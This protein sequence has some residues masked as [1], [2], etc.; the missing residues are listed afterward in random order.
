VSHYDRERRDRETER[1]KLYRRRGDPRGAPDELPWGDDKPST[2]RRR[3]ADSDTESVGSSRVTKV[4]YLFHYKLCDT[5]GCVPIYGIWMGSHQ[6]CTRILP[7]PKNNCI[8]LPRNSNSFPITE[9]Q[10]R[11]YTQ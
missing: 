10:K 7:V 4:R 5:L 1:E 3:R 8:V 6:A 9:K 2:T 11:T